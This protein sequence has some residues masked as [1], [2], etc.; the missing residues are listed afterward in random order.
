MLTLIEMYETKNVPKGEKDWML[1]QMPRKLLL[2]TTTLMAAR[3]LL[4][5]IQKCISLLATESSMLTVRI[6]CAP[7]IILSTKY[8][9]Q[10][11]S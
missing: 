11:Q 1:D 9:N 2:H 4:V 10:D 8:Q 6:K 3:V 7:I 5:F